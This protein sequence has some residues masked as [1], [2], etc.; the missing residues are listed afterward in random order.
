M[1][2]EAESGARTLLIGLDAANPTILERLFEDGAMPRTER[3]FDAGVH[4]ELQ[5]Q[6]PPWTA[7]AW[8]SLYT[9]VNPGRHGVFG[10]LAFDGYDW[11]LVDADSVREWSLWERCDEA[12]LTSVVVNVP[13]THPPPSIDGAIVPGYMAPEEPSCHP[14]GI[15]DEVEREIGEY[16]IYPPRQSTVSDERFLSELEAL[17]RLRGE[18]FRYLVESYTPEFGFLQFQATDTVFHTFPGEYDAAK[19][20]YSAV[21]EQIAA[22]VET[23]EP[24]AVI[25]ASDH[26]MGS[27]TNRFNVNAYLR[28]TGHVVATATGDGMPQW[29]GVRDNELRY[30]VDSRTTSTTLSE[31]LLATVS[32]VGI[33]SQRVGR[34]LDRLGL[35]ET[36][37]E[38]VPADAIRAAS[39]QVDFESSIAYLRSRPECGIRINLEGREPNGVVDPDRYEDVRDELI[40]TLRRVET[41]D[42]SLVFEDVAERETYFHGPYADAAPD[43]VTVPHAFD[44]YL[45]AWLVDEVFEAPPAPVRD[46]NRTGIIA[47]AGD[48]IDTTATADGAHLFDVAP[49]VLA[50]LDIAPS[51]RMDG[52]SLPFVATIPTETYPPYDQ[53]VG[54]DAPGRSVE[55]RLEDLG[56]IDR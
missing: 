6:I 13:V 1:A 49:T 56:Y 23:F 20:V 27:Y 12:G 19:A 7:S 10:F 52:Q 55:S 47:A 24:T 45:G 39:E 35:L 41:P 15:L 18:A 8:P 22:T 11:E 4:G 33:T 32:R 50:T 30:G 36:A 44:T 53:S 5:S 2:T 17:V 21:D 3:L 29:D 38:V 28:Q 26:G 43:V 14:A 42:G 25:L 34:L 46:H 16:R 48:R 31:R 54:G 51:D 37:L 40:E 9:G